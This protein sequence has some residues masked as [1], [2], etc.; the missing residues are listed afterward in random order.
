MDSDRLCRWMRLSRRKQS[1]VIWSPIAQGTIVLDGI[2]SGGLLRGCLPEEIDD[3]LGVGYALE[4]AQPFRAD[5]D[6]D[7][8]SAS[9]SLDFCG[10]YG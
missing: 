7:T 6:K 3:G 5:R 9:N 10:L 2:R 4:D 8:A 1:R